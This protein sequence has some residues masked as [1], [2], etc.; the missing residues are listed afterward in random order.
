M[1]ILVFE[2]SIYKISDKE[3]DKLNKMLISN[4][5]LEDD[6]EEMA[7]YI[8]SKIDSYKFVGMVDFS[9]RR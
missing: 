8:E 6:G 4:E 3:M 9:Y 1:K 2:E 5:S 7:L